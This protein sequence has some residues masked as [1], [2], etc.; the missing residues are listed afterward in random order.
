MSLMLEMSVVAV[1]RKVGEHDIFLWRVFKHL[2]DK[3]IIID[4][5]RVI[6]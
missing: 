5:S 1:A 2:I 6:I 4:V 3:A